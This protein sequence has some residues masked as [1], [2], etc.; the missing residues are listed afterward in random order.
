MK[1]WPQKWGSFVQRAYGEA[2]A[3]AKIDMN[4]SVDIKFCGF[5]NLEKLTETLIWRFV[6]LL[7]N[8]QI[9]NCQHL[10]KYGQL[11]VV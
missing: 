9:K 7:S 10:Y 2:L 5:V 6:G 11:Q 8:H 4:K 3:F 1:K